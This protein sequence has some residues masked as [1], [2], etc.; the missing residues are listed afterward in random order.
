MH[1]AKKTLLCGFESSI[2]AG[3][4]SILPDF[5]DTQNDDYP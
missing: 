4:I 1:D 3:W 2:K 5:L